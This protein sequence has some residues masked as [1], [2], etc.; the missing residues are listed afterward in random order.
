MRTGLGRSERRVLE[1]KARHPEPSPDLIRNQLEQS[2]EHSKRP[3]TRSWYPRTL[4]PRPWVFKT[5]SN[6]FVNHDIPKAAEP[7][8]LARFGEG[9]KSVRRANAF[10]IQVQPREILRQAQ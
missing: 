2:V 6:L 8:V 7:R 9:R 3:G 10:L 5:Y 1:T 4:Q